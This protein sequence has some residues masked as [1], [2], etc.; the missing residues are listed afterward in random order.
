MIKAHSGWEIY[1][2]QFNMV[3]KG[4]RSEPNE[5]LAVGGS[6]ILPIQG[7]FINFQHFVFIGYISL[8][9]CR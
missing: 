8:Y 7:F 5:A 6:A 1:P 9:I 2:V 3:V 4:W